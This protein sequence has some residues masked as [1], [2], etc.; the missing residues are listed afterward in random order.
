LSIVNGVVTGLVTAVEPG[1]IKAN[2]PWLDKGHETDWIRVASL[3]GGDNRGSFF[4]P[5]VGDEVLVAFDH[6]DTQNPYVVGFLWN[7]QDK[8]P[9]EHVRDRKLVSKN[10]HS[11]R[12]LDATPEAG[13]KGALVIEDAHGNRI[14]MSSGK[15]L[16]QSKHILELEAQAIYLT[17]PELAP[18]S[19]GETE[20]V[21]RRK[22]LPSNNTI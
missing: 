8:P 18:N 12:F 13:S 22:V 11:I 9:G 10:G 15:I 4:M 20:K 21:W 19:D 3:M 16:I 17:G 5:E 14:T 6:G 1:R 2:Y 7:G